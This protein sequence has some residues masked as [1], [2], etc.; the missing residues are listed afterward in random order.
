MNWLIPVLLLVNIFGVILGYRYWCQVFAGDSYVVRR[1]ARREYGYRA[2]TYAILVC[3]FIAGWIPLV[4]KG[5]LES[6][7]VNSCMSL[8]F[9]AFAIAA[10]LFALRDRYQQEESC[11]QFAA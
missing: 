11:R 2:I 10:P 5:F 1:W 9:I 7:L 4:A 3:I 6:P 8:V